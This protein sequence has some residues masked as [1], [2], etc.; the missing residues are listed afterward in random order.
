MTVIRKSQ[1]SGNIYTMELDVAA[2]QIAR[3]EAGGILLQDA[4]PNLTPA[5]REFIKTGLTDLEWE[6]VFGRED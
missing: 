4:F 6:E 1:Y 2:E 3:Y 5:E